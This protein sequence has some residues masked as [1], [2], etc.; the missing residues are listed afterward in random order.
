[1]I[2]ENGTVAAYYGHA[3]V[4]CIHVRPF[5]NLK[6]QAD[7]DRMY[8]ISREASDLVMEMGGAMSGEHGDGLVRSMWNEKVFG[9]RLYNA[10]RD[11]NA[12]SIPPA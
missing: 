11:V 8:N 2:R 10:F 9:S 6:Q 3:S 4:G 12:P 5:I 7:V 1:M